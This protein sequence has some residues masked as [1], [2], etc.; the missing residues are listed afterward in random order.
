MIVWRLCREEYA[1]LSGIGAYLYGGRWNSQG[2]SVVY[3]ASSLSLAFL[4]L[5]PGLRKGSHPKGYVSLEIHIS[6]QATREEIP[7]NEFPK[8]WREGKGHNWFLQKGDDWIRSKRNLLLIVPS[9]IVP[10]E[11][12]III[13]PQHHEISEVKIAKLSSFHIDSRFII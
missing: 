6:D 11:Y 4:E 1:N 5:L 3:T 12:N 2:N 7:L 13:N 8:N 10:S 9:V